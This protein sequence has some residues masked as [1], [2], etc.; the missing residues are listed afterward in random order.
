ME[1]ILELIVELL[2]EGLLDIVFDVVGRGA[3]RVIRNRAAR[4][5]ALIG[6]A[7]GVGLAAGFLWG[8][9]AARDLDGGTPRSLFVSLGT[10]LVALLVG[11]LMHSSRSE[12]FAGTHGREPRPWSQRL[13]TIGGFNLVIAAGIAWGAATV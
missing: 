1:F 13:M 2:F 8:A 3:S 7:A 9:Y 11:F 5:A 12:R 4:I 6:V 10:G